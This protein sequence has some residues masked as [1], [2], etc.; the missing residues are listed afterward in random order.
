MGQQQ[1]G[2]QGPAKWRE[3]GHRAHPWGQ[4]GPLTGTT[5]W[6]MA[7]EASWGQK[8]TVS[9]KLGLPTSKLGVTPQLGSTGPGLTWV[10][11]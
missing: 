6:E 2:S 10:L 7:S 1:E 8:R 9:S 3:P 5:S 4:L 11:S